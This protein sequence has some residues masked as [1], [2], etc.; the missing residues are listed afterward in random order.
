MCAC[1]VAQWCPTLCNPMDYTVHGILQAKI[2]CH[3]LLQG[4]LPDPENE[5]GSPALQ[6]DSLLSEPPGSPRYLLTAR[7]LVS[8]RAGTKIHVCKHQVWCINCLDKLPLGDR[9]QI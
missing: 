7:Q 2:G 1:L 6:A 5:P 4:N 9:E 8:S 3:S